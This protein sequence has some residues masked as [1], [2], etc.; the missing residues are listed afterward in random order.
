MAFFRWDGDHLV[1]PPLGGSRQSVQRRPHPGRA[2]TDRHLLFFCFG[3]P[4]LPAAARRSSWPVPDPP[5]L[6]VLCLRWATIPCGVGFGNKVDQAVLGVAHIY[7]GEGIPFDPEGIMST[8]P[9]I[10]EV[11][12][13]L[14]RG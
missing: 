8:L 12:L 9:A 10:V 13:G 11:I 1:F 3:P 4:L 14:P 2:G 7:K 6:W 5:A